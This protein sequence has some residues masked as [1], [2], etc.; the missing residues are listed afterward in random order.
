MRDSDLLELHQQGWSPR[1]I[2]KRYGLNEDSVRSRI[3]KS[4]SRFSKV[5][6][7]VGKGRNQQRESLYKEVYFP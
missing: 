4:E 6:F 5:S 7:S 2:A 3:S 1:K